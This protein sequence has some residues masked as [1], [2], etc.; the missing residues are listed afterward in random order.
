MRKSSPSMSC[1]ITIGVG[2]GRRTTVFEKAM[3]SRLLFAGGSGWDLDTR[4]TRRERRLPK[5]GRSGGGDPHPQAHKLVDEYVSLAEY[6]HRNLLFSHPHLHLFH[7]HGEAEAGAERIQI[8]LRE[9]YLG[10]RRMPSSERR[11]SASGLRSILIPSFSVTIASV[12]AC[13]TAKSL[14]TCTTKGGETMGMSNQG[15]GDVCSTK[16][17]TRCEKF[18]ERPREVELELERVRQTMKREI[19]RELERP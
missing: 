17:D 5:G 8:E 14:E 7:L 13:S 9:A 16:R 2:G 10:K 4:S 11:D 3:R 12:D 15:K 19:V 6:V 18:Q 1:C